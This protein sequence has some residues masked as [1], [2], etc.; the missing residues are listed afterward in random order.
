MKIQKYISVLAILSLFA[1]WSC[2]DD[3]N[4]T[5]RDLAFELLSG[6]W[7]LGTEGSIVL[8]GEDISLNY[9]GFSVSFADGTYQT[10]NAADLFNASGTWDWAPTDTDGTLIILDTGELVTVEFLA[11][12]S[13]RFSFEHAGATR[14]GISGNYLIT[15]VK[16]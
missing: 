15:V 1:V 7:T 2:K 3:D 13:L 9:P 8:D 16:P 11:L 6:Q 12:S 10:T 14:A 4:P 5:L